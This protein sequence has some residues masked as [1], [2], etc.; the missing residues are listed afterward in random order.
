MV[1]YCIENSKNYNK[2]ATKYQV[3]YQ[4]VRSW[5]LKYEELGVNG[6]LDRRRKRKSEGE[7]IQV[8]KL[9]TEMKLLEAQNKRL[10]MEN[11]LNQRGR[12]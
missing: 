2:T 5:V 12:D 6:L 7:L 4:Q 1:K 9:K 8:D 10:E 11:L 3:S